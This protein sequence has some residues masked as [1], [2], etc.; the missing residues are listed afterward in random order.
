MVKKTIKVI[1]DIV[2]LVAISGSLNRPFIE[3]LSFLLIRSK[4]I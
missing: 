3:F 1:L 2:F 4:L